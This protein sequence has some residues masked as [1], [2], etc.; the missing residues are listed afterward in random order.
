MPSIGQ[1]DLATVVGKLEGFARDVGI[2]ERPVR[3]A[4]SGTDLVL[5]EET[6]TSERSQGPAV[7][8]PFRARRIVTRANVRIFDAERLPGLTVKIQVQSRSKK[9]LVLREQRARQIAQAAVADTNLGIPVIRSWDRAHFGWLVEDY[10]DGDHTNGADAD[11]FAREDATLLYASLARPRLVMRRAWHVKMVDTVERDLG[12]V[13]PSFPALGG[14]SRW[15][16]G[17]CHNDLNSSNLLS[18]RDGRLWL[19]DWENAGIAPIVVDLGTLYVAYPELAESLLNVLRAIDPERVTLAPEHQ[20][21]IGSMINIRR[22]FSMRDRLIK[23][24]VK[25]GCTPAE[26][27]ERLREELATACRHVGALAS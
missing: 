3:Y 4:I 22:R 24:M 5:E 13:A 27:V 6:A 18:A 25:T 14:G 12:L 17:L 20:L 7:R 11:R 19:V 15:M 23:D 2:A 1:L 21:A 10:V 26:A 8:L 16:V 9:P